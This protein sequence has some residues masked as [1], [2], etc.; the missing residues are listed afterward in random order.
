MNSAGL[1]SSRWRPAGWVSA[2]FAIA[3]PLYPQFPQPAP[4][5]FPTQQFPTQQ[6]DS[7]GDPADAAE[8]G[9]ARITY[10]SGTV[11]VIRGAEP[12]ASGVNAPLVATDRLT[13]GAR[14]RAEIQL[15]SSH[16][17]RLSENAEVRMGDLQYN[18]YL[19]QIAQGT[20][21]LF[22]P[23]DNSG[24][25]EIST[26]SA[27]L[28]PV[29][30][31]SYRVTVNQD[32]TCEF[33]VRAGEA[34]IAAPNGTERLPVGQ[35]LLSRG[36]VNDPEFMSVAAARLDEWDNWNQERDRAIQQSLQRAASQPN[37]SPDITGYED[38]NNYGRWTNDPQY[39][40]VW[41][42]NVDPSWAP[43]RDGQWVYLD[44]YGWTWQGN[45]PWGWAPYH[46]GNWYRASFGW[47]WY[48]GAFGA[49]HYWRPALVGFYGWGSP[50][51]NIS[52]G[53]GNI[54]WV[55]LAPFEVYRP[56]YGR[57]YNS[58]RF[59]G[60][61]NVFAS[62]RNS[63]AY[64]A[65]G[66]RYTDFGHRGAGFV[67]PNDRD[68]ARAPGI[69]PRAG[70]PG[71]PAGFRGGS[72]GNRDGQPGRFFSRGNFNRG[73]FSR[74]GNNNGG[75]ISQPAPGG[76]AGPGQGNAGRFGERSTGSRVV[77]LRGNDRTN[78]PGPGATPGNNGNRSGRFDRNGRRF[79]QGTQ[80]PQNSVP[81]F[82]NNNNGGNNGGWSR[83]LPGNNGIP[84]GRVRIGGESPNNNGPEPVQVRPPIVGDRNTGRFGDNRIFD[85]NRDQNGARTE[86]LN[87]RFE[88]RRSEAQP[89]GFSNGSGGFGMREQ[90]SQPLPQAAPQV[91]LP[92]QR[93]APENRG[94]FNGGGQRP[95]GSSRG[96]GGGFGRPRSGGGERG[97][98]ERRG[99]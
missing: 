58:G 40:N 51:V 61:G 96:D 53:F 55:P 75:L 77:E 78:D 37:V 34:E 52:V 36:S 98:G 56:W 20:V 66:V 33:T 64:P 43:Y 83:E 85:P 2:L 72:N 97:G 38:L 50:G 80:T 57:G 48:P 14:S 60:Q 9:V 27:S 69:D 6:G 39:G 87:Q 62:F 8:H 63:R 23:R 1:K 70:L 88:N 12:V 4:Q 67:R 95:G 28:Q 94:G 19:L 44:Y 47:A 3:L 11:N 21:T 91:Q 18:R 90:R 24:Q 81:L 7:A 10:T 68:L 74:G 22:V 26:P 45:E 54:G 31:G 25:V 17:L 89:G 5:Q 13:T 16:W 29:R 35:T 59:F 76:Q 84:N 65:F 49:R 79:E 82:N 30:A 93:P 41:A 86:R 71:A 99:R 15:D 92:Q 32:G 46:Y 73:D 42:P